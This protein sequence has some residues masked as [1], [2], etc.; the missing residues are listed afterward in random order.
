MVLRLPFALLRSDIEG[1]KLIGKWEVTRELRIEQG[2]QAKLP[3]INHVLVRIKAS[4][5]L[6]FITWQGHLLAC[7]HASPTLHGFERS[8][9]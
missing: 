7:A 5:T 4:D 9:S 8:S 2:P 1:G 6:R 3:N